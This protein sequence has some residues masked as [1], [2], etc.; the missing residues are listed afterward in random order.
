M[1]YLVIKIYFKEERKKAHHHF[2]TVDLGNGSTSTEFII[3]AI[4]YTRMFFIYS[5][6][7]IG[8]N[9]EASLD[10]LDRVC[11]GWREREKEESIQPHNLLF[12]SFESLKML[13]SF[14]NSGL[15][16][17][18]EREMY[19]KRYDEHLLKHHSCWEFRNFCNLSAA[20]VEFTPPEIRQLLLLL[21]CFAVESF[22]GSILD[23]HSNINFK[24]ADT[25]R[26]Y[27]VCKYWNAI[28]FIPSGNLRLRGNLLHVLHKRSQKKNVSRERI[29]AIAW[30]W[31]RIYW[32]IKIKNKYN[33]WVLLSPFHSEN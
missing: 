9:E 1:R 10:S 30:D 24:W 8:G 17:Q 6:R 20:A 26:L 3:S 12:T 14:F 32:T 4:H 13:I 21:K 31:Q 25:L 5:R 28:K 27:R 2:V 23:V 11:R 22:Q 29:W 33:I 19:A 15:M 18:L 7:Y 16:M